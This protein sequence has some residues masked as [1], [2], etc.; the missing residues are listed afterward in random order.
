[1]SVLIAASIAS[2]FKETVSG[3]LA[4]SLA[5]IVVSAII[6]VSLVPLL[7]GLYQTAHKILDMRGKEPVIE[8]TKNF[9]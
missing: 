2:V 7:H 1:V 5:V 3:A 6:L 4:D 8:K 9:N